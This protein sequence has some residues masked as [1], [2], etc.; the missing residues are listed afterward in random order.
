MAGV[1]SANLFRVLRPKVPWGAKAIY[2]QPGLA[3]ARLRNSLGGGNSYPFEIIILYK[4]FH[5][6]FAYLFHEM[7]ML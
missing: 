4:I 6:Y 7:K 2:D 3:I 5:L 1:S